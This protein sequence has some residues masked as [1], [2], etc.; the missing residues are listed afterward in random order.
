MECLSYLK[1]TVVSQMAEKFYQFFFF[2]NETI[3]SQ[4]NSHIS[5]R[6][7]SVLRFYKTI[8]NKINQFEIFSH[9]NYGKLQIQIYKLQFMS[10]LDLAKGCPDNAGRGEKK[11]IN[12]EEQLTLKIFRLHN[13]AYFYLNVPLTEICSIMIFESFIR[14]WIAFQILEVQEK[15]VLM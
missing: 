13:Q 3:Y 9:L 2:K 8:N 11:V 10:K 15:F 6:P 12:K 7:C 4:I 14:F 5:F 1:P